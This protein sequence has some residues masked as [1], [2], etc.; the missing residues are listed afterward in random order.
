[1]PI[2]DKYISL[3]LDASNIKQRSPDL[4]ILLEMS[5]FLSDTSVMKDLLEGA[6][7]RLLAD[8]EFNG[9]RIYR[10]EPNG[11]GLRLAA[12]RGMEPSG[13]ETLELGEGFTG[14]AAQTKSFLAQLVSELEDQERSQLLLDKGF[15]T[16][17]CVPMLISE[18]VVGI[19]NLGSNAAIRLERGRIDLLVA[20]AN[21]IAI[22]V[23]RVETHR[24]L[25][26]KLLEL[27]EKNNTIKFFAYSISHDLKNPA[28]AIIGFVERLH[29]R[30][31]EVLESRGKL[32]V[33]HILKAAKQVLALVEDIN[34][35]VQAKEAVLR[36]EEVDLNEVMKTLAA[37]FAPTLKRKRTHLT[38]SGSM[39]YVIADRLALLRI[40]RNFIDNALKYGGE[41]L[42]QITVRYFNNNE[43]HVFEVHDN[44]VGIPAHQCD[45]LFAPFQRLET[46]KGIEGSGLGLAVVKELVRRHEGGVSVDSVSGRG[47]C[48]RITLS[49]HPRTDSCAAP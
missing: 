39:P 29:K 18:T 37:E 12:C 27:Q 19:I 38:V 23:D 41:P 48:F 42:S 45:S 5:N 44:G 32:Y 15:K 22:A 21:Q 31:Y 16:I 34:S 26:Q 4:S 49:K 33:D 46:S 1:M 17:V 47:T 8:F 20:L 6:L 14:K 40:F 3:P 43:N 28:L 11:R 9:G 24:S 13:L 10:M 30:Y 2:K 25:E 36:L 35:Y 7:D